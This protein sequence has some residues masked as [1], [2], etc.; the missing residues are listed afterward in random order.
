MKR[1]Y[2][3]TKCKDPL[4]SVN[5][6]QCEDFVN[7][8]FAKC[9]QQCSNDVSCQSQCSRDLDKDLKQCPCN[10]GIYFKN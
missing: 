2:P 3:Y 8:K 9:L 7:N 6:Q 5:Y 4:S 1:S 10:E